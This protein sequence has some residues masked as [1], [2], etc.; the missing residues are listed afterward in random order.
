MAAMSPSKPGAGARASLPARS[1][2][3]L[4]FLDASRARLP[5]RG[6]WRRA[7]ALG[8]LWVASPLAGAAGTQVRVTT[9][10][11]AFTIELED[12]RAPLTVANFLRYVRDGH[13]G[14][15]I[16]H[17]VV[18]G[19]VIQGGGLTSELAPKKVREPIANESGN[20]LTNVRGSV[21]LARTGAPH[22]GDAQFYV[23][24]VDNSDLN[25]LPS[26]WG[27]AVFGRI[28]DGM[29][30]VDRIG[31]VPTGPMGPLKSD[32]PQRTVLIEKAE[33][34]GGPGAAANAAAAPAPAPASSPAGASPDPGATGKAGDTPAP[35]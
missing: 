18:P 24:L 1:A 6:P 34:V 14:G 28:V 22:S 26:R 4:A 17:R 8:L 12:E 30:V 16:F 31:V 7:L 29:D 10:L 15:T 25:P 33:I 32:V 19:F 35:R 9:N 13:Y 27:Y 3:P 5:R 2:R 23:N 20:G 21:G 11:G